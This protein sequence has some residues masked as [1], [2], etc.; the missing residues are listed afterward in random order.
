M[1]SHQRR[2]SGIDNRGEHDIHALRREYQRGHLLESDVLEDPMEQFAAWFEQAQA[3]GEIEP[4]AMTLATADQRGIPSARIVL[5]KEFDPRGFVFY[6]NYNSRKGRQLAENPHAALIFLWM[7]LERQVRVEGRV[8]RVTQR[9]S[10]DYFQLR[11]LE[12]R[13]GAWAS[14][15]SR[16]IDSRQEL[17][18]RD[19]EMI[20]RFGQGPVP[21]P[22]FWGGYRLIPHRVEFWQG[23]ASRLHDRLEYNRRRGKW[24]IRRLAP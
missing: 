11:P 5:L 15:Q 6:T 1:N 4:N 12:A 10:D 21:R 17:E 23:R 9:E 20:E 14:D 22:N 18:R 24:T 13:I 16:V 7:K 2:T 19:A 3:A 8:R